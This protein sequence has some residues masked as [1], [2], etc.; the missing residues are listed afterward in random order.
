MNI[1]IASKEDILKEAIQI[2]EYLEITVS[3]DMA[4]IEDR[5][6]SLSV[7]LARSGKLLADSKYHKDKAMKESIINRLGVEL[8]ASV[9]N[10]LVEASCEEESYLV[11]KVE[12]INRTCTH[13]MDW[14]RS[15][16]S[17][18]KQEMTYSNWGNPR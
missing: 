16:L 7:F 1:Q 10:K 17:K 5:G 3:E 12:R 2:Q 8:P 14:L 6:S 4:E 9:L 18:A 15:V 13:Q 11:N